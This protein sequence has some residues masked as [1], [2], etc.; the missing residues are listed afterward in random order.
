M[1][2]KTSRKGTTTRTRGSKATIKSGV[3][4]WITKR[5]TGNSWGMGGCD[6]GGAPKGETGMVT[7][8]LV[9]SHSPSYLPVF[10]PH[11]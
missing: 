6:G 5:N 2:G 3:D 8:D 9:Y 1:K 10:S 4:Q 11:L 7:R